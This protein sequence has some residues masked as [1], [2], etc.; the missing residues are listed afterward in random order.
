MSPILRAFLNNES[1]L[2]RVIARLIPSVEVVDDLAQETFLRASVAEAQTTIMEPRAFLFRVARNLAHNERKRAGYRKTERLEDFPD[3]DVFGSVEEALPEDSMDAKRTLGL[4]AEAVA[5]MPKKR[6]MAFVLRKIEEL[7]YDEIAKRMGISV[8]TVEK[9]VA[10]GLADCIDHLERLG[11]EAPGARSR[12]GE[13][14]PTLVVIDER[15]D[16][17]DD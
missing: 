8:K 12:H 3:P 15:A 14:A 4:V 11:R 13:P 16:P 2:K 6:R 10:A 5:M 9:H 17:R 7:S 1:A